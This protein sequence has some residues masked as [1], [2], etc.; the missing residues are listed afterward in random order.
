MS[1][2]L[3]LPAQLEAA[4]FEVCVKKSL[5]HFDI[6]VGLSAIARP[7]LGPLF[8]YPLSRILYQASLHA[9]GAVF[10]PA[11]HPLWLPGS[12]FWVGAD[13]RQVWG[14]LGSG[15]AV[16]TLKLSLLSL[17]SATHGHGCVALAGTSPWGSPACL[18]SRTN[19]RQ[20][21]LRPLRLPSQVPGR[22]RDS[23]PHQVL[24]LAPQLQSILHSRVTLRARV[25]VCME[26]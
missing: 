23:N 7:C 1:S 18:R 6:S 22:S 9:Q 26:G 21:E 12:A 13:R 19:S 11:A 15:S 20:A 4:Y 5:S 3:A 10:R 17:Q 14:S 2:Q 24:S 25:K 16:V 8:P